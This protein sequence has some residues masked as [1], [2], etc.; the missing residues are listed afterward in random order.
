M[1][2]EKLDNYLEFLKNNNRHKKFFRDNFIQYENI[3]ETP[4]L[5]HLVYSYLYKINNFIKTKS[6][7]SNAE[8]RYNDKQYSMLFNP[9]KIPQIPGLIYKSIINYSLNKN[10]SKASIQN[11]NVEIL[12]D[13]DNILK[14]DMDD[15][16]EAHKILDDY[17]KH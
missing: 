1:C 8:Y 4:M 5:K 13:T 2:H 17:I 14:A 3:T 9:K 12:I 11:G 7:A 15:L 10:E 6:I 16:I